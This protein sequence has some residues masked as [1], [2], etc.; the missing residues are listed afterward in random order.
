MRRSSFR[1]PH[2]YVEEQAHQKDRPTGL[3]YEGKNNVRVWA[4]TWAQLIDECEHRLKFV[5][6]ALGY[7]PDAE[8]ALEYLK[9]T[10]AKYLPDDPQAVSTIGTVD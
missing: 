8:Q 10:Y 3:V 2:G 9:E 6:Q 1:H 7:T 4:K 5:Q